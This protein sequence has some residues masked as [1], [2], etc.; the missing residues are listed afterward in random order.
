MKPV[1]FLILFV[2]FFLTPQSIFAAEVADSVGTDTSTTA[3]TDAGVPEPTSVQSESNTGLEG[4]VL[5]TSFDTSTPDETTVP[6]KATT[7][8]VEPEA[9][10]V[11]KNAQAGFNGEVQ[12]QVGMI[13]TFFANIFGAIG[14]GLGA[15]K[16]FFLGINAYL[17]K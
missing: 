12:N 7:K 9:K 17:S 11:A 15:I 16:D 3:T 14:K 8:V 6:E 5:P 13:V 2:F 10:K 4:T 1:S